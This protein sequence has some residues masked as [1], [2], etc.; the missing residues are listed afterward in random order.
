MT[1]TILLA[2][3]KL[4]A[5]AA[6]LVIFVRAVHVVHTMDCRVRREHYLHW[7]AF[8]T[9]YALLA[10]AAI[11]TIVA[12]W[13]HEA[14]YLGGLNWLLASGGLILFDRRRRRKELASASASA[15]TSRA[16]PLRGSAR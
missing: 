3:I 15:T 14:L 16:M 12:L 13:E 2:L 9:A 1:I 10:V 11:G 8:G 6:G 4:I 7:L 5:T